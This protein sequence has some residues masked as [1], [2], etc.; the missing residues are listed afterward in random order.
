MKGLLI[1]LKANPITVAAGLVILASLGFF[2]W[3][4][5]SFGALRDDLQ[6]AHAEKQ[7]LAAF[8]G[9]TVQLPS[10]R[11]DEPPVVVSGVTYNP[12]TVDRMKRIFSDLNSQ[13]ELTIATFSAF[14][15]RGHTQ[16]V[17]GYLPEATGDTF[18][19]K[20][21]YR[22][23]IATLLAGPGPA[24]GFAEANGVT[25]PSLQAGL[26]PF[27]DELAARLLRIA[28]EGSRAFGTE[29]TENQAQSLR[30]EQRAAL[31]EE[32]TDRARALDIYA[33]PDI[34]TPSFLNPDFP[35]PVLGYVY[36]GTQPQPWQ[37][38][39]SQL[40]T[41]IL[42]DIVAAICLA[43][44]VP[45]SYLPPLA[46]AKRPEG[47][48]EGVLGA[49]VKRLVSATVLPGYVGLQTMGGVGALSSEVGG[50]SE[51]GLSG[52]SSDTI[53]ALPIPGS[54]EQTEGIPNIRP[55]YFVS[56]TGRTSNQV[57]DVRHTRVKL[58]LDYARLPIFLEAL[59]STNFI[60]VVDLK[61]TSLDEYDFSDAGS[62]GGPFVY[63]VG[64]MVEAEM[65]LESLW[66][67]SWTK[68]LMPK[69]VRQYT[70]VDA[71]PEGFG[72]DPFA[73]EEEVF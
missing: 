56:P 23:A 33:D 11:I 37:L 16:L 10:Q 50:S 34:G 38:W 62:L 51:A 31:L 35:L 30:E 1:W 65:I 24:A 48:G 72:I 27:E 8:T 49:V 58:H 60:S 70:G 67:R 12:P 63:G 39:E 17:E 40:Q 36:Q 32:L 59:A 15:Q 7:Q 52:T 71:P 45:V 21:R 14:N 57:F 55:N 20:N 4:W 44:D 54:I 28:D 43:N 13:T 19:Y 18:N 47:A 46:S 2:V 26:A 29:L 53:P 68:P 22:D 69:A 25:L 64:K 73:F 61:V 42:Q 3:S 41:W 9:N 6:T 5:S 66:F